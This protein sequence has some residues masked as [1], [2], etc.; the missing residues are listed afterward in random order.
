MNHVLHFLLRTA[1]VLLAVPALLG[2]CGCI[3]HSIL[4]QVNQ[5]GS[6]NIVVSRLYPRDTVDAVAMQQSYREESEDDE[7]TPASKPPPD[8]F[9]NQKLLERQARTFG[10]DVRFV[11][12]KP[13][14][15][16]G[17]RG[18]VAMYSF[19]DINDVYVDLEKMGEMLQQAMASQYGMHSPYDSDDEEEFP[20]MSRMNEE[21]GESCV[22]FKFTKGEPSRL[23]VLMPPV[24][25]GD[26]DAFDGQEEEEEEDADKEDSEFVQELMTGGYTGTAAYSPY[27]FMGRRGEKDYYLKMLRN[28][29]VELAVEVKGKVESTTSRH[30][31]PARPGRISIIDFAGEKIAESQKGSAVAPNRYYGMMGNPEQLI[32]MANRTP[33]AFMETNREVT[34]VFK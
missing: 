21:R 33:G 2:V 24:P 17:A 12:A 6:G 20:G 9:Y 26:T 3:K 29:K 25:E 11:K 5:D 31:D 28:M 19:A 23:Q 30:S 15:G 32:G 13:F 14:D 10:T 8:P 27:A 7:A 34:V 22:E 16:A 18:W 4:V 1:A